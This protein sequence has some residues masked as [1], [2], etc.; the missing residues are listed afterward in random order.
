MVSNARELLPDP[1]RP[2][3]TTSLS[4]GMSSVT[5][6]RLCSPAPTIRI[7]LSAMRLLRRS[8][9]DPPVRATGCARTQTSSYRNFRSACKPIILPLFRRRFQVVRLLGTF[10]RIAGSKARRV[11]WNFSRF[12][13]ILLSFSAELR[14]GEPGGERGKK[15]F[16]RWPLGMNHSGFIRETIFF[17]KI[18]YNC[19]VRMCQN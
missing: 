13:A 18:G 5:P 2:V 16:P 1:E 10:G 15:I 8:D 12:A 11:W 14:R 17:F 9:L 3:I 4:R 19:G 6:L 7:C